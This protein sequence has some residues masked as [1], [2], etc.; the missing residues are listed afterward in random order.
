[1]FSPG[2]ILAVVIAIAVAASGGY[3]KGEKDAR[4][5]AQ[6][7]YAKQLDGVIEQ[8][9]K[10]SVIDMTAAA[11]VAAKEAQA[12]TRTIYVRSQ[13]DEAVRQKPAAVDCNL[14]PDRYRVL[15]SAVA[16]ANGDSE[17]ATAKLRNAVEQANKPAVK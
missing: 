13:A 6:A 7:A 3:F 14:T 2:I 9:N 1:M 11:E 5:E 10:D 15:L 4:N 16:A 8:H 17:D 12:K